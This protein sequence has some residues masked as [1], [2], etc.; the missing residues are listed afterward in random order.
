[1]KR[2]IFAIC[3][4][5][6]GYA[7]RLSEYILD[8]VRLPYTLH[9]FT[10][11]EELQKFAA[12]EEIAVLVIAESALQ[13]LR[14]E[15]VRQ[16]VTQTFV[17]QEDDIHKGQEADEA[18]RGK[19][20]DPVV[21]GQDAAEDKLHYISKFQSP[22]QIVTTLAE[23]ITDLSDWKIRTADA[24]TAVKL[25][26]IYSPVKR[27]LQTSFAITMGQILAK[28]HRI[29]YFNFENYSGFGQMLKREFA[30]D[31][32]DLMY[33]FRCDRDKL[34]LR[35]PTVTQNLNGLDYIPPMQ[36]Y[37][38]RREVT[39]EQWLEL[40]RCI[41]GIG[42]YE[43]IILDLDDSMDGLF[44]L[45]RNCYRIYTITK[46]D[47]FAVAKINQYEQI[48]RFHEME[49]I[50]EKTVKCRFPVFKDI[51]ADLNLMTH[52]ELAGYVKAIIREDL[53]GK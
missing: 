8:K 25:I 42:Q 10:K 31:M 6:E 20:D 52:G 35:L 47:G 40:C 23:S 44:D 9:L 12:Q 18:F 50:V 43:Y 27:C 5:E 16:H 49:E 2:K 34:A 46:E 53:Y 14:K 19:E 39:G 1:M 38:G 28:E 7:L 37:A 24:D 21:D 51:T 45:L 17:L 4:M 11:A 48:L 41:A 29:L 32:M 26:G 3:D 15:Y 13:I 36:S 33:Y 30:L 22:E